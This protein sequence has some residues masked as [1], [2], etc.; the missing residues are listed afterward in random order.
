MSEKTGVAPTCELPPS[1]DKGKGRG[2]ESSHGPMQLAISAS[3]NAAVTNTRRWHM[4]L[5]I[6]ANAC[7]K[8]SS[9]GP[10]IKLVFSSNA[11]Y[12]RI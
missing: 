11:R 10:R 7:S 1:S 5:A 4:G 3:C 12:R 8:L 6:A 2:D 9:Y